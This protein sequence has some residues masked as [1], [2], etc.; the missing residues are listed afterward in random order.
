[1]VDNVLYIIGNGFDLHHGVASS[2]ASFC[3]WLKQYDFEL[4]N[5]YETVCSY[6]ALWSDFETSMAYV[7][8]D[9][10]LAVGEAMLPDSKSGP[11]DWTMADIILGGDT[12]RCMS[13]NLLKI[14]NKIFRHT[15]CSI[16]T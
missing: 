14:I 5:L 16:S 4:F 1:M 13:E 9:Y 12:A 15:S 10:F 2:Y 6:D 7:D 11:D 3:R 8:R